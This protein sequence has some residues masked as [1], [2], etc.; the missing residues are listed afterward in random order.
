M[1][2]SVIDGA[3]GRGHGTALHDASM[4]RLR[5]WEH[6]QASLSTDPETRAFQFYLFEGWQAM[7]TEMTREAVLRLFS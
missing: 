7:G 6:R 5:A 1:R 3:H 2:D 4:A